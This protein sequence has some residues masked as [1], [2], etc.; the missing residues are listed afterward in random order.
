MT[1]LVVVLDVRRT[2]A[3]LDVK[4]AARLADLGVTHVA[5]ARDETTQAVVRE[6]WVFDAA[7]SGAEATSIVAGPGPSNA[8]HLV[9]QT[10]L[11]HPSATTPLQTNQKKESP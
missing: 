1:M 11:T 9:F 4:S 10:V 5:I 3:G 6:G 7:T 2:E 8:L